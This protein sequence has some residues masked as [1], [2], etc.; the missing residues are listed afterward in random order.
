M[1]RRNRKS[2]S[3][4]DAKRSEKPAG[5]VKPVWMEKFSRIARW[6]PPVLT[7]IKVLKWLYDHWIAP[8]FTW[9]R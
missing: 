2:D 5:V 6:V 8:H 3:H 7:V 4:S 9:P 1:S